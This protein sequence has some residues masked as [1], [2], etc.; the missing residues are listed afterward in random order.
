M[1]DIIEEIEEGDYSF[2]EFWKDK[3]YVSKKKMAFLAWCT[4][5][6]LFK[7][8]RRVGDVVD[9]MEKTFDPDWSTTDMSPVWE[10]YDALSYTLD[11]AEFDGEYEDVSDRG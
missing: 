10:V 9:F 5:V 1:E 3:K 2:E 11:H 6:D 7:I 4:M 8:E